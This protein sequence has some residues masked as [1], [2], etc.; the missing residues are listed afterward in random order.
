MKLLTA[1][2]YAVLSLSLRFS[3]PCAVTSI[4]QLINE[5]SSSTIKVDQRFRNLIKLFI[6]EFQCHCSLMLSCGLT[7]L[8]HLM[9]FRSNS[10]AVD[11][12]VK[13]YNRQRFLDCKLSKRE[14]DYD[15]LADFHDCSEGKDYSRWLNNRK[16]YR[17]WKLQKIFNSKKM[18]K[19]RVWK[20]LR[21]RKLKSLRFSWKI[22]NIL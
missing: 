12:S 16:K 21:F 22:G 14:P 18:K 17:N 2:C 20:A 3:H 13:T 4:I 6:V 7:T 11:E 1:V 9:F 8:N 19:V 5:A 10:E 15:E